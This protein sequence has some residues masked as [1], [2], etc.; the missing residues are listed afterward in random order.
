MPVDT[1]GCEGIF[2]GGGSRGGPVAVRLLPERPLVRP[3]TYALWSWLHPWL[4]A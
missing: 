4:E 3:L 2:P 1:R